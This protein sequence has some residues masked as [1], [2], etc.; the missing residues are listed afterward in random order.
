MLQREMR[1]VGAGVARGYCLHEDAD[2]VDTVDGAD[3]VLC[4]DSAR[5]EEENVCVEC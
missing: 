5:G 3:A 4:A 1:F 2:D